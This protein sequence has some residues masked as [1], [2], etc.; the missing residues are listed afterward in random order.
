MDSYLSH[1]YHWAQ[2]YF[3][4]AVENSI[5]LVYLFSNIKIVIFK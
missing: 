4:K 5:F 2:L 3:S 1:Q